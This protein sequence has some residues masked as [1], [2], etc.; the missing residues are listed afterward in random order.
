MGL[1]QTI[2][3]GACV[4]AIGWGR[5]FF[6]G[7]APDRCYLSGILFSS[8]SAESKA[9]KKIATDDLHSK[10]WGPGDYQRGDSWYDH[11]FE[12]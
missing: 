3:V 7:T 8:D 1:E 2:A 12:G 4:M 5:G 10:E 9:P 11:K 6:D